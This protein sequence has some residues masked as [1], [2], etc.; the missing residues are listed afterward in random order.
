MNNSLLEKPELTDEEWEAICLK[1]AKCCYEKIDL[2]NGHIV[3]TEEPCVYL[4]T[5]S[6]MCKIYE[7]RHEIE[8]DCIKLNEHFIRQ[9]NWMPTG[10]A[11]VKYLSQKDTLQTVRAIQKSKRLKRVKARRV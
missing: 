2:G 3:Y 4:D 9:I 7:K 6:R 8:P 10:C 1:C 5:T 11:Y